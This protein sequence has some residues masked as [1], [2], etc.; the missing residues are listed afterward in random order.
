MPH[1]KSPLISLQ[2]SR[3]QFLSMS[4]GAAVAAGLGM[5][6]SGLLLPI[7]A[8]AQDAQPKKGGH[9]VIAM[10]SASSS[11]HLDPASYTMAYMY[12]VG[13]QLFNTLLELGPDGKLTSALVE[14]WEPA[15]ADASKWVFRLRKGVTFHNGKELT[16]KD[17]VYSLNNHRGD[18]TKSGGKGVL[19]AV[20]DVVASD[21]HEVTVTLNAGNVDFPAAFVDYHLGIGPDGE[22]FDKGIGTGAFILEDF[23]PGVR[24]LTR[25]NPNYWH[26]DRANVDSVE[27]IAM[28]DTTA[29]MAALMSGQAH[30]VNAVEPRLVSHLSAR[31][32][33]QILRTPENSMYC[34]PMRTDSELLKNNDLRLALKY[35]IDREELQKSLLVGTGAVG[36]DH[37]IPS[38]NP[39]YSKDVPKR[40]Y[41][42]EKAAFHLKK[43]GFSGSIPLSVSDNGFTGSADAAQLYQASAAKAGITIDVER[44]PSDGYWDEVWLK[45]PFVASNWSVRP[46]ADAMLSMLLQTGAPW[47]ETGWSN[48]TFDKLLAASRVE[49][50]EAKRKQI[51]HDM[52]VLIVEDGGELI[53]VFT[54]NLAAASGKV[55]GY[56]SVPGGG[57]MSGY[58][59]AEKVWLEE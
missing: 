53:P 10:H 36:N 30:I 22:D 33:I 56:V 32:D 5:T 34:F 6:A 16:A 39:L 7:Q 58:R 35:A 14:S 25:R 40:A 19:L 2:P 12:T 18:D 41:D 46:T 8:R 4:A 3:R 31:P 45:K 48:E 42:P 54:D 51:Y 55:K 38:W 15:N 47:N 21:T 37:P 20:T 24:A 57:D 11:D 43:S 17:V 29:R 49:L 52:Q 13:F 27:T 28:D 9:L 59:L 26:P 1:Q 50:D 23:Q 44:V